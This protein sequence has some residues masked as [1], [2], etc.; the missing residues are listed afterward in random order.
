M[1]DNKSSLVQIAQAVLDETTQTVKVTFTVDGS[2]VDADNP[3]PVVIDSQSIVVE[4]ALDKDNDSVTAWQGGGAWEVT[5]THITEAVA[6]AANQVSTNTKLDTLI[7][8]TDGVEA[9]LTSI[10]SSLSSID[11]NTSVLQVTGVGLAGPALRVHLAD[12]SLVALEDINVTVTNTSGSPVPVTA[13]DLDIRDIDWGT[14]S[15]KAVLHDGLNNPIS[16]TSSAIHVRIDSQTADVSVSAVDLDIRD[17]TSSD[18]VTVTGGILQAADVKVTLDGE[19]V[20]VHT[21]LTQPLTDAQLRA[22]AVPVYVASLPLP[23]G[24][25]T[26]STLL[27]VK[28]NTTRLD[29]LNRIRLVYSVTNVTTGAWVELLSSIGAADIKEIEIFDSSGETLELGVGAAA[30]EV[31][32]IYVIPGGNGRIPLQILA[33][34]RLA[35]QAVSATAD[36]G[37]I[38]INLYG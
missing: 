38:V 25:A 17:L 31:S 27:D 22:T 7:D 12:E 29:Y 9:S 37:E 14:D 36:S 8:Q 30:S 16:S 11:S 4:V 13:T 28:T 18:V 1:A 3:L 24:A 33:G 10:D 35:I 32:K 23:V 2:P 26:E 15:I 20:T 6:T 19:T 21:G 34:E 5:N